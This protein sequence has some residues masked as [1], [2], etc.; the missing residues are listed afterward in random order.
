[1]KAKIL[2]TQNFPKNSLEPSKNLLKPSN[3]SENSNQSS[4]PYANIPAQP[5]FSE[6][7]SL[8]K[9]KQKEKKL[10]QKFKKKLKKN[11]EVVEEVFCLVKDLF[12][13]S[14]KN[15][16]DYNKVIFTQISSHLI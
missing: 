7:K 15:G 3:S 4:N 11:K 1:M 13:F 14:E 10:V 8:E 16:N 9:I 12:E 5:K 6:P 2:V